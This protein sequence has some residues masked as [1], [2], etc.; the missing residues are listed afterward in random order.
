M[1]E[2]SAR[3]WQTKAVQAHFTL[4]RLDLP[5]RYPYPSQK[6]LAEG[7]KG[8]QRQQSKAEHPEGTK[9]EGGEPMTKRNEAVLFGVKCGNIYNSSWGCFERS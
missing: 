5:F 1:S 4:N 6:G 7:Q 3:Q 9:A 2:S 8:Q